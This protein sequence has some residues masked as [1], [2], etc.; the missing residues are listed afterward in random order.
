MQK[1][2]KKK[3]KK[4][5]KITKNFFRLFNLAHLFLTKKHL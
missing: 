4:K 1:K 2:K 5:E 3:K